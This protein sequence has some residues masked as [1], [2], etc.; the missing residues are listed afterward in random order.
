M[1]KVV[2]IGDSIRMGYQSNVQKALTGL[3]EVWMPD[4]NG[5]DSRNVLMHLNAWLETAQPDV[6]HIN[7]GL[8]D[9]K[10]PFETRIPIVLL[11]EYRLN[12]HEILTRLTRVVPVVLWATTTPVNT[13]WHHAVKEFDRFEEDVLDYNS[14][15]QAVARSL[16]VPVND[17]YN[18]V[19][20]AGRDQLLLPDGVHFTA[21]GYRL[22]AAQVAAVLLP[23]M[24]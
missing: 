11:P 9:V 3:A 16:E 8:H 21:E 24:S 4:I 12:V 15:A 13:V 7:C 1:K 2:L 14:A 10:T 20:T 17:L 5:G 23:Y 18:T 22:L 19:M 6:V